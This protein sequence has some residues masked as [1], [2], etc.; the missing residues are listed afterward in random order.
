MTY[1]Q[2]ATRPVLT[3]ALVAVGARLPVAAAPLALVFLVR[4]RDGGYAIGAGLGASYVVGEVI[5]AVVLGSRL[6][7]DR[8]R[9]Q[10]AAGLAVGAAA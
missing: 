7:P 9:R 5:G 3:W 1:R 2:L 4:Q 10:L 8:A 6:A